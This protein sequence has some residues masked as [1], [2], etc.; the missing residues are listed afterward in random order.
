MSTAS[1]LYLLD[2]FAF[3]Y[4]VLHLHVFAWICFDLFVFACICL[5]LRYKLSLNGIV[6][7][8]LGLGVPPRDNKPLY[9][10]VL[11]TYARLMLHLV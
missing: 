7:I 4:I 5:H 11:F 6:Y 1:W 3:A 2:F 8:V 10:N 9:W